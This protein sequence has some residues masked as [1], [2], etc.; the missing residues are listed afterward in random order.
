[1]SSALRMK[2]VVFNCCP[3]PAD[4]GLARWHSAKES[5]CKS[6]RCNRHRLDSWV[7]K[8]PWSRKWQATPV[9]LSGKFHIHT[10]STHDRCFSYIS[11]L[12][13]VYQSFDEIPQSWWDTWRTS[14]TFLNTVFMKV[15]FECR[16]PYGFKQPWIKNIWGNRFNLWSGKF[17]YPKQCG[18]KK[19]KKNWGE[20]ILESSK[21]QILCLSPAGNHLH[22]IYTVLGII[23]NVAMT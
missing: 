2:A 14:Q 7:R 16:W 17:Q 23:S 3:L 20:E 11:P 8:I 9:F 5:V 21:K 22:S 15:H 10:H 4:M 19:K 6:R 1:M 13:R 18:P 12:P